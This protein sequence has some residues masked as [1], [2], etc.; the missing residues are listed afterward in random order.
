MYVNVFMTHISYTVCQLY[1]S[2]WPQNGKKAVF[3]WKTIKNVGDSSLG[4]RLIFHPTKMCSLNSV[5]IPG[6]RKEKESAECW[7]K[8]GLAAAFCLLKL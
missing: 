7:S 1:A 5:T 6:I 8:V 3:S 2:I 4:P